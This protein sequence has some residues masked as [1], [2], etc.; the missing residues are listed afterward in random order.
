MG[1]DIDR[2]YSSGNRKDAVIGP[3]RS[4]NTSSHTAWFTGILRTSG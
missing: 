2:S 1:C 4:A 3:I